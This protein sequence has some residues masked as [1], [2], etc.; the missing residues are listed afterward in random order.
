MTNLTLQ[1]T[2]DRTLFEVIA[3]GRVVGRVSRFK[4]GRQRSRPWLWSIGLHFREGHD[5]TFGYEETLQ[6]ALEAFARSW[7]RQM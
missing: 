5:P 4:L 7:H 2:V 3:D 1:A 6:L